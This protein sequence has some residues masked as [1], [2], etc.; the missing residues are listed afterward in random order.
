M[1]ETNRRSRAAGGRSGGPGEWAGCDGDG[2]ADEEVVLRGEYLSGPRFRL[3]DGDV[4]RILR[5]TAHLARPGDLVAARSPDGVVAVGLL[6]PPPAGAV[7]G[8]KDGAGPWVVSD[9]AG[10]LTRL[11]C[12][13]HPYLL[14][15]CEVVR[16]VRPGNAHD[17]RALGISLEIPT[18]AVRRL[19][20]AFR[21]EPQE[22]VRP[23]AGPMCV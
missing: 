17:R 4:V 3:H 1:A 9:W 18:C 2:G 6:V 20:I 19:P 14:G 23:G 10:P 13:G 21:R 16:L 12:C 11:C 22:P 15:V 7:P 5:G 8:G